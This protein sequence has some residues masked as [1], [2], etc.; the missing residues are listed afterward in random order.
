MTV[1]NSP[2]VSRPG[3]PYSGVTGVGLTFN[4][5]ASSDPN[6]GQTLTYAWNFGDGA[7]GVGV[8]VT[9]TYLAPGNYIASLTVT[10]NGSPVLSNTATTAVTIVDYVP[11]TIIRHALI[12][13]NNLYVGII[14]LNIFGI[15]CYVRPLT[16]ID[17]NSIK[18]STTYP[19]AGTVPQVAVSANFPRSG[20]L[21]S[22]INKNL[23]Y[24]LD[25]LVWS[26]QIRPLVSNVPNNTVITLVFTGETIG[27]HVPVRGTIDAKVVKSSGIG[28]AHLSSSA[29]PNP[30]KPATTIKY[31]VPGAGPV[32]IRVF[33]VNGQLVRSL[34]EDFATPGSYEVRWNGKDDAGRIAPSGIYFVSVKQ[35]LETSTTRVV[36][37]R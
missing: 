2:P 19:N 5:S 23:F 35:G 1:A 4:G 6:A 14:G 34:R 8:T 18:I 22:D 12:T 28:S 25:F 16:E 33:S 37:A 17:P 7:T 3:G 20:I 26:W 11:V 10:D 15:E 24:D 36:L 32:S 31:S 29:T 13:G 27:D 9:H 30:F 21:I